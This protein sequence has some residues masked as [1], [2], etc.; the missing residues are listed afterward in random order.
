[1]PLQYAIT[2]ASGHVGNHLCRKLIEQGA[3]VKIL[4]HKESAAFIHTDLELIPGDIRNFD[5]V[6]RLVKDS[7]IVFHLAAK[8]AISNRNG[9]AIRE[10]NVDGTANVVEACLRN[11]VKRLIHFG[12]IHT[13]EM[14]DTNDQIDGSGQLSNSHTNVYEHSKTEAEKIVT[15]AIKRGLDAV[16]IT[17]TAIIGP[18]DQK[19]S[20][21]GQALIK[22]NKNKIPM[23]I[24]GGYNFVDV[25]DVVEGAIRAS[26]H[27]KRG[28][29]YILSGKWYS[30]KELS[31][32]IGKISGSKTPQWVAPEWFALLG[33][34]FIQMF[35]R[36]SGLAPLYTKQSLHMLKHSGRNISFAKA[37]NDLNYKPRPLQETLQDTFT[38]YRNNNLL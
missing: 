31:E 35:A 18:Y 2:G 29:R 4:Q 14:F 27:G 17:P 20:Y 33:L 1:M 15:D 25:R 16:I 11:H 10:V 5:S 7:D 3:D 32:M 12:S 22:I 8:I 23:L 19:P 28:E 36:I 6:N 34:P 26:S 38:W 30:L 9:K 13:L 24:E 21:L 37:A